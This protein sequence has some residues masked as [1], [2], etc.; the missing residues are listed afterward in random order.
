MQQQQPRGPPMAAYAANSR[1]MAPA[2]TLSSTMPRGIP[3]PKAFML[4][5][6]CMYTKH[7]NKKRKTW[8]DGILKVAIEGDAIQV[9][10]INPD[11]PR[12]MPLDGRQLEPGE[13]LRFKNRSPHELQLENYI[14]DVSF[15]EASSG[16][17]ATQAVVKPGQPP[18][19]LPK[20][21][22]P[23]RYIP[24]NAKE[25]NNPTQITNNNNNRYMPSSSAQPNSASSSV[26]N[27]TYVSSGRSAYQISE[28]E[29]DDI[30][31]EA[32][33][34]TNLP[35]SSNE[36]NRSSISTQ[37]PQYP[38]SFSSSNQSRWQGN[39]RQDRSNEIV[40][41]D[42]DDGS[43]NSHG[44][45]QPSFNQIQTSN[46]G[47]KLVAASLQP[48]AVPNRSQN[49]TTSKQPT[50]HYPTQ[51]NVGNTNHH[52]SKP[53]LSSSSRFLQDEAVHD[54]WGEFDQTSSNIVHSSNISTSKTTVPSIS[55]TKTSSM[56]DGWGDGWGEFGSVQ[57]IS[58][59]VQS[60]TT[61]TSFDDF[62]DSIWF[63]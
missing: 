48:T 11:D 54:G 13:V 34:K 26:A 36:V 44:N 46:R 5:L 42:V 20:F 7:I 50:N 23:S 2:K 51:S 22:P 17:H 27:R 18:L 19:K 45:H 25:N 49:Q 56:E 35:M 16:N 4:R 60:T 39:N 58:V 24:P 57:T 8:S 33:Q 1:A 28:S 53:A 52:Q 31:G 10:L 14:V 59:N 9:T 62:D 30:W 32:P 3:K 12:E 47:F 61:K 40:K 55:N 63:N 6:N 15:D 43:V 29:L 21:V 38:P 37:S 41:E